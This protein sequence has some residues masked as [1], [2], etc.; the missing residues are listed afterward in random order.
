MGQERTDG[1]NGSVT[2]YRD[3]YLRRISSSEIGALVDGETGQTASRRLVGLANVGEA[4][5]LASK[6]PLDVRIVS[7]R[8][9]TSSLRDFVNRFSRTQ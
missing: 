7:Y 2:A 3:T 5:E 9:P 8:A 4:L 1:L 6:M